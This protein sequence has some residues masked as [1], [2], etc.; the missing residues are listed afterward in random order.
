MGIEFNILWFEDNKDWLNSMKSEVEEIITNKHFVPK[1]ECF[2]S[3]IQLEKLESLKNK[4][5]T[6]HLILTDL[7]LDN[8]LTGTEII[9]FFRENNILADVLFYSGDGVAKIKEVMQHSVLEGVYTAPRERYYFIEKVQ[10]LI[11]KTVVRFE[12]P[13]SMR[14]HLINYVAENDLIMK[15]FIKKSINCEK[16]NRYTCK[17]LNESL[18][19]TTIII[20]ECT[21]EEGYSGKCHKNCKKQLGKY[22]AFSLNEIGILDSEKLSKLF[23]EVLEIQG[24]SHKFI[25]K[26]YKDNILKIRNEF[27]HDSHKI[28]TTEE[29]IT[30]RK[31]MIEYS[32]IISGIKNNEIK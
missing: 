6:F 13:S 21:K 19:Y 24:N 15:E 22:L 2:S 17:I 32:E 9:K 31:N 11:D 28:C 5:H 26:E 23:N 4:M 3:D 25:R 14:N 1:T 7:K 30:I 20:K 18:K 16:T 27:A 29:Y 8:G 12:T 10:M